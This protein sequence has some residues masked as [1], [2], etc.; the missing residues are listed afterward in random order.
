MSGNSLVALC[1][2]LLAVGCSTS[3]APQESGTPDPSRDLPKVYNPATGK[4]EPVKDPRILVD[5]VQW[6]EIQSEDVIESADVIR[7]GKKDAYEVAFLMPMRASTTGSFATGVDPRSRRFLNYYGG[8]QLALNKLEQQGVMINARVWDTEESVEVVTRQ[9]NDLKDV[10]LIVGPY[11]RESLR[12]AAAFAARYKIPVISPWTPSIDLDDPNRYFVQM[13]P[14]LETHARIAMEY[15]G[16]RFLNP[17]LFIVGRNDRERA[18]FE[19]YHKAH[20]TYN[21]DLEPI[22]E[23]IIQDNSID[24]NNTNLDSLIPDRRATVFI[25]PY[26]SRSDEDFLGSLLRKLHA[27]KLERDVVVFGLPQWANFRRLNPDYLESLKVHITVAHHVNNSDDE[28]KE[29][30]RKFFETYG[31]IPEPAAKQ[32]YDVTRFLGNALD[33]HG[34]QFID[35]VRGVTSEYGGI[36]LQPVLA[37]DGRPDGAYPILYYENQGL[38]ILR[39]VEQ[40]YREVN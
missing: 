15:I 2:L 34:L 37:G 35:E 10:D 18:R 40:A 16:R 36:N 32:A 1:V 39:F 17:K 21:S 11:H 12:E 23:L 30:S 33:Q 22:E 38:S 7:T 19:G 3:K 8:V 13:V 24:L 4:Y 25:L 31:S 9:L 26:Y 27:E 6:T 5:T 29:F 14:G 20:N 28:T